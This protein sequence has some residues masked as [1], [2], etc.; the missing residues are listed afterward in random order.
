M[1]CWIKGF[2]QSEYN[3]REVVRII[4]EI[5]GIIDEEGGMQRM[6]FSFLAQPMMFANVRW[7]PTK[8]AIHKR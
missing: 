5:A 2:V 6:I 7:E 3:L 8:T 4:G 1:K